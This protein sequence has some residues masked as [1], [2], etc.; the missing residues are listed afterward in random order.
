M[1]WLSFNTFRY[2]W[3]SYIAEYRYQRKFLL[4]FPSAVNKKNHTMKLIGVCLIIL[5]VAGTR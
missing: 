2:I 1:Q 4:F 3:C 5:V